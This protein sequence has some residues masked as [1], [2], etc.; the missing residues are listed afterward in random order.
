MQKAHLLPSAAAGI[1]L[2]GLVFGSSPTYSQAP[3]V[4]WASIAIQNAI[5]GIQ[6]TMSTTLTSMSGILGDIS[7]GSITAILVGGFTQNA[8]YAKASVD[9]TAQIAD[10]HVMATTRVQRDFRNAQI[11]D[12]HTINSNH[13]TALDNGQVITVGSGQSRIVAN[14]I[15]AVADP[16]GEAEPSDSRNCRIR[17]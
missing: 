3:V 9:A 8:N 16:R 17:R 15:Q 13:C 7:N 4:D 12:E 5:Q 14:S 2:G 11:R 6:N 10:G 1:L